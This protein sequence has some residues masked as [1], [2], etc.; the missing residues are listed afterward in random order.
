MLIRS[1][2]W[3]LALALSGAPA[4]FAQAGTLPPPWPTFKDEPLPLAA[5]P[6]RPLLLGTLRVTLDGTTLSNARQAIG[7][8]AS[9]RQGS[10]TEALDWLCYTLTDPAAAPQRMWLTSSELS[11][12]RID[13]VI[14]SDLAAGAV[15]TPDCPELPARFRPVRFD[16]GLWLGTPS[17][18]LRKALGMTTRGASHFASLFQ[19]VTGNLQMVSSTSIEFRG[20]RAVTLHVAH[21]SAN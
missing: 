20:P 1:S 5:D 17:S 13:G 6:V 7:I 18:E 10:G 11:R 4:A 2:P 14:A 15:A 19:G 21:S 16:D 9:Q 12:G 8:G 3:L